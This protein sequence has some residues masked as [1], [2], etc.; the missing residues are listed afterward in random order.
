M[1][2]QWKSMNQAHIILKGE[3]MNVSVAK[4]SRLASKGSIK[5]EKD[6]LDE[7]VTL[8]DLNELRALFKS[9]KKLRG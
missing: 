8:V 7:R 3:G 2:P 4:M 5:V 9:S 6:P 1:D